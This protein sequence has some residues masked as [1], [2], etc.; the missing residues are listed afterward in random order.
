MIS[1]ATVERHNLANGEDNRDGHGENFSTNLGIEGPSDDPAIHGLRERLKRF[2][3]T[4]LLA[5]QGTPMLVAGDEL[6]R[7]QQGN[8]NA[9]CQDNEVSWVDWDLA[10]TPANEKML[11]FTQRAVAVRLAWPALRCDTF[12]HGLT[13]PIPGLRDIVWFD[14]Q[15]RELTE[16]AWHD[17][18]ARLLALRRAC[19]GDDG[20][21]ISL[22][23]M[24]ASD[25]DREFTLP[26]PPLPWRL[27]LDSAE[28][29]SPE[30]LLDTGTVTV[31]HR[32][33]VI[34]GAVL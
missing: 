21:C 34:L 26:Q 27:L 29:D 7:T 14:E 5:S 24:N 23:L 12:L 28:P 11:R 17:T 16:A 33:A 31:G 9:Y 3:I 4:L 6:G 13:E 32:S 25:E 1:S 18:A 8:N 10:G 19:P 20:T 2:L 30:H 15:A 22:L